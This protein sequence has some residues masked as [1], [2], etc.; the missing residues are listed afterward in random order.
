MLRD[1][2][3][4]A[5]QLT[6]KMCGGI[7]I[8]V[9]EGNTQVEE[10]EDTETMPPGGSDRGLERGYQKH[11]V[12]KGKNNMLDNIKN[13]EANMPSNKR[14]LKNRNDDRT[15]ELTTVPVFNIVNDTSFVS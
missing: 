5:T 12:Y 11:N 3:V 6:R 10:V 13:A 4:V 15:P 14:A 2:N 1:R 8:I 9:L 7:M